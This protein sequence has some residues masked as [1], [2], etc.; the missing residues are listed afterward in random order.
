MNVLKNEKG[1]SLSIVMF[2]MFII[3]LI[4]GITFMFGQAFG[5]R[6]IAFET[7]NMA[8]ESLDFAVDAISRRSEYDPQQLNAQL[9]KQYFDAAFVQMTN[10]TVQGNSFV[11]NLGSPYKGPITVEE[12]RAIYKGDRVPGGTAGQPGYL[13]TLNVPVFGGKVPYLGYQT[14]NVRMKQFSVVPMETLD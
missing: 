2:G 14:I 10:T 13:V 5:G 8:G 6:K 7:W 9:A 12:F 11:P 4:I 3:I 1:A